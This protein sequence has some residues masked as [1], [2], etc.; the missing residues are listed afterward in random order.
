MCAKKLQWLITT[1]HI[2]NRKIYKIWRYKIDSNC[3]RCLKY[4]QFDSNSNCIALFEFNFNGFQGNHYSLVVIEFPLN[5]WGSHYFLVNNDY[6]SCFSEVYYGW[7]NNY[8]W[9]VN[10]HRYT[11]L[12]LK[13]STR[14]DVSC[15][16][17]LLV[18]FSSFP[19]HGLFEV[20]NY[21]WK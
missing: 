5:T 6:G 1:K 16:I 9:G 7:C 18:S 14:G 15:V 13:T 3:V 19:S 21:G 12:K 8:F 10:I 2:Q 11:G 4:F 20:W 17:V